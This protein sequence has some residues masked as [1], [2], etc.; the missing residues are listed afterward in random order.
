MTEG[1]YATD[2]GRLAVA[3]HNITLELKKPTGR[4]GKPDELKKTCSEII[5]GYTETYNENA[6]KK[7]LTQ[8]LSACDQDVP[9]NQHPKFYSVIAQENWKGSP[10]ATFAKYADY[11]WDKSN[12]IKP[13]K[14]RAFLASKPDIKQIEQDPAYQY[15]VNVIPQEYIKRNLSNVVPVFEAKKA[16]L[17]HLY[18]KALL[19]NPSKTMYPDANSTMR[20]TYGTIKDYS[21]QD[22]VTYN[23][24]TTIEG[25]MAKY[26]A[27]DSEFDVP[28]NLI[29]AYKAKNYGEY[30]VNGTLPVNFITDND[31]TGGNSGSPVINANGELIGLAFD[32]NW[33]AMSGDIAF[34]KQYKRTIAVDSRYVL[35]CID[36]LGGAKNIINELDIRRDTEKAKVTAKK[37]SLK[38]AVRK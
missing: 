28:Q 16:E 21:P 30:G 25:L 22:G 20:I 8:I 6:D 34:D 26:K 14:L 19:A 23:T 37:V 18:M 27:G 38:K 29:A 15:A 17:D 4:L 5:D 7:M 35:W 3:M 1:L 36:V 33:E 31:I 24:S 10:E 2:W 12:L 13:E 32:G 11:I 9:K